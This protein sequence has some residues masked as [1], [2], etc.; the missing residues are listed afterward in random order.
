MPQVWRSYEEVFDLAVDGSSWLAAT[1]GGLIRDGR[2]VASPPGLRQIESVRPLVVVLADGRTLRQDGNRW[3]VATSIS[4][5]RDLDGGILLEGDEAWPLQVPAPP[6]HPYT[7]LRRGDGILAGTAEGLYRLK[8]R[9]WTRVSLPSELPV[10]RPNGIA[11]QNGTYVV[12]GLGGLFVGRPGAW[13]QSSAD[14]IRQVAILGKEIWAL[15]GNGAVDKL[16]LT[17]DRLYPDVLSGNALR[18]WTSSLGQSSET[19]LFGGLGGWTERNGTDRYPKE[20]EGDVATAVL[21]KGAFR[22]IGTQKH[23]LLQFSPKGTR[24]WNP[25]N[26]LSDVWVTCL[27]ETPDGLLVGTA[28]QG[29]FRL[30]NGRILPVV[31]P[32]LRI[33]ALTSWNGRWILGGMEGAW[34]RS[35]SNWTLLPTHREETTALS[36][37]DGR[38]AVVTAAGVYFF[39]K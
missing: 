5:S 25:G 7:A 9:L 19:P 35:G 23:G 10:A 36:L 13:R 34:I 29:L 39:R 16:D 38:L 17:N 2:P 26:G 31:A 21:G 37:I 20:L 11:Y 8:D 12:G 1:N 27:M 6:A 3:V 28:R 33:T 15:H 30:R 4:R 32:T 24:F 14:A 22:W 18:P